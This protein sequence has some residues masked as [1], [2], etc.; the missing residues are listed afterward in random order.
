MCNHILPITISSGTRPYVPVYAF[1]VLYSQ[2]DNKRWF[3]YILKG[4][5]D[6][7]PNRNPLIPV[8]AKTNGRRPNEV[9]KINTQCWSTIVLTNVISMLPGCRLKF[10]VSVYSVRI[11]ETLTMLNRDAVTLSNTDLTCHVFVRLHCRADTW[12]SHPSLRL[13]NQYIIVRTAPFE[14]LRG[15]A[16]WSRQ[17]RVV[18]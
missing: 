11:N 4:H 13:V 8:N 5:R 15:V 9:N 7:E 12:I 6:V 16:S 14:A 10:V 1:T 3:R 18:R 2:G 17:C